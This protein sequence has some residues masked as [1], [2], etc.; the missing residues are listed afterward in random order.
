MDVGE[1][2]PKVSFGQLRDMTYSRPRGLWVHINI[3][4]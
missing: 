4:Q 1:D 2:K 3:Y